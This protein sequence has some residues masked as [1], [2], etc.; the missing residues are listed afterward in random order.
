MLFQIGGE[1]SHSKLLIDI[2]NLPPQGKTISGSELPEEVNRIIEKTGNELKFIAP[3]DWEL[4]LN[5]VQDNIMLDA[6]LKSAF[7]TTCSRCLKQIKTDFDL[8]F[9]QIFLLSVR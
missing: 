9:R 3:I 5:Q 7:E 6:H 8:D 4:S 2:S 1:M